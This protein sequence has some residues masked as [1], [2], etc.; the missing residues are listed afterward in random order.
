M[1]YKRIKDSGLHSIASKPAILPYNYAVKWITEHVNPKDC[2]FNDST[3]SQLA[4]FHF[5]VFT[6]VYAL[7]P[8]IQPLTIECAQSSKTRFNFEEMLKSWMHEP[9]K[10]LQRA[11]DLYPVTWFKDPYSLLAAMLCRL[12]HLPNSFVFK[13]EWA[14]VGHHVLETNDS[15]PWASIL[16]LELKKSIQAYQKATSRKKPNFFFSAFIFYVF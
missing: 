11:D 7:K 13:D 1:D 16:S 12:Y 8:A 4:N 10:L 2:S 15:F 3:G 5:E 6:R 9:G 14:P